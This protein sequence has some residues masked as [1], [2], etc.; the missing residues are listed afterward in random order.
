MRCNITSQLS[1]RVDSNFVDIV[2]YEVRM[3]PYSGV[4][5]ISTPLV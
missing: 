2:P 3:T 1:I 4:L 5:D